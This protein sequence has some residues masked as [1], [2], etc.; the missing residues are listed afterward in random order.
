MSSCLVSPTI[1]GPKI[2]DGVN[3]FAVLRISKD[4]SI[5]TSHSTVSTTSVRSHSF[6]RRRRPRSS[7]AASDRSLVGRR[8]TMPLIEVHLIEDVFDTAQK[9]QIIEKLTD[10]M[11][12]IEGENMRSVT[13]VKI[14]EVASGEWGIGG[15]AL[16]TGAVKALAAGKKAA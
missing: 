9:Q 7:D 6:Y 15:Q 14:S 10:A 2:V 13:W 4:V 11:V 5:S 3:P 16:T 1:G 12:S 8:K